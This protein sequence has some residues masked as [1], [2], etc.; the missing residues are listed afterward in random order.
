MNFTLKELSPNPFL[1]K[2]LVSGEEIFISE[3]FFPLQNCLP[4]DV[5]VTAS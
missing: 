5:S 3:G 1:H 2:I 4:G